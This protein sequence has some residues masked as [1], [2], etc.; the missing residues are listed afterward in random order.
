MNNRL[1]QQIFSLIISLTLSH[2]A[3]AE[4]TPELGRVFLTPAQRAA[5]DEKRVEHL[6]PSEPEPIEQLPVVQISEENDP[7]AET[8]PDPALMVNGYV[9][10]A[11]TSG[12]VWVNGESSYDGDLASSKLDHLQTK[13]IGRRVRLAPLTDEAAVFVK[14]GQIYVPE[15]GV[16]SDSYSISESE[17]PQGSAP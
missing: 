10:R 9:K 8:A 2:S 16:I 12:T 13:I 17:T 11:N 3:V 7:A 5:L 4:L 14:P 1:Q 15:E 6:Q